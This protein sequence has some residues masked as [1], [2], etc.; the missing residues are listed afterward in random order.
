[1]PWGCRWIEP[2]EVIKQTLLFC[3]SFFFV[4]GIVISFF[5]VFGICLLVPVLQVQGRRELRPPPSLTTGAIGNVERG[6]RTAHSHG[7]L[8]P[9]PA[10]SLG[11]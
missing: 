6:N 10:T 11:L 5:F 7:F 1:M 4:P 8:Y 9:Q 3:G 2:R